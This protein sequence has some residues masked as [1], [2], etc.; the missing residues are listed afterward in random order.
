MY[1]ASLGALLSKIPGFYNESWWVL[2]L[3]PAPLIGYLILVPEALWGGL[4]RARF[5]YQKTKAKKASWDL[6]T[7]L[8]FGQANIK[9]QV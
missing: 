4:A 6:N 2:T 3:A 1:A 9:G 5:L 7:P 8:P